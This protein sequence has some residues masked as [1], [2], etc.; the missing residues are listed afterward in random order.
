MFC[1]NGLP[2]GVT[3]TPEYFQHK[4]NEVLTGL[5]GITCLNDGIFIYV[6]TEEQHDQRLKATLSKINSAGLT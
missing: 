3:S 6:Y 5:I 1:F 4:M 2:F